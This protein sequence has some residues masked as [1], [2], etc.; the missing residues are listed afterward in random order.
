MN[1][2]SAFL[3]L[4]LFLSVVFQGFTQAAKKDSL[5]WEIEQYVSGNPGIL[6]LTPEKPQRN[7]KVHFVYSGRFAGE[8]MP[9]FT[10][11]FDKRPWLTVKVIK[12]KAGFEGDFV[13]PDSALSFRIAVANNLR[14]SEELLIYL[15]YQGEKPLPGALASAAPGHIYPKSDMNIPRALYLAEFKNNP[16]LRSRYQLPYLQSILQRPNSPHIGEVYQVWK[17]SLAGGKSEVFLTQLYQLVANA[18]WFQ[19]KQ[20]FKADLLEKYPRGEVAMAGQI[21]LLR[22]EVKSEGFDYKLGMLRGLAKTRAMKALF[23]PLISER[24]AWLIGSG[25]LKEAAPCFRMI[26]S[27]VALKSAYEKSART[28][29]YKK[30]SLD[31]AADY[32]GKALELFDQQLMPFSD[33]QYKA[34]DPGLRY[35]KAS[36]LE[37]LAEIEFRRSHLE[38]A[39]QYQGMARQA[40]SSDAAR[41]SRYISYL[42]S[43]GKHRDAFVIADSCLKAAI[44]S[45]EIRSAHKDGFIKLYGT[46]ATY[47]Q[48]LKALTDSVD[49]AYKLPEYGFLKGKAKDFKL[50]D[51][52]G[53]TFSLSENKGKRIVLYFVRAQYNQAFDLEWNREFN[54]LY[55]ELNGKQNVIL[56]GIDQTRLFEKDSISRE[57][58][59]LQLIRDLVA[60]ENYSFPILMDTYHFDETNTGKCYF[61][62]SDA[63]GAGLIGGFYLIDSNGML[64]YKSY[65]TSNLTTREHFR[66][67]LKAALRDLN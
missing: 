24:I 33:E 58:N 15:V 12:T 55:Q 1:A 16:D 45:D 29:L 32:A 42:L 13:V 50:A 11:Y 4:F 40:E 8:L 34:D 52:S 57:A 21:A 9:K 59:R 61:L 44:Y 64:R 47:E 10:V 46:Q 39:I 49:Q 14:S 20:A 30:A 67:E 38:S 26:Q 6:R 5:K 35:A 41:N 7:S 18:F 27:K 53:R 17:D 37:L 3:I 36:I 19:D 54:K 48:R 65:P 60:K 51:L 63:Y 28:L 31:T 23:D 62:T 2:R 66:R 22:P 56:V 43:G 25:S